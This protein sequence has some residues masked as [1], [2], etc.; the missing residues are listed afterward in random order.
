MYQVINYYQE[1]NQKITDF[2]LKSRY[3]WNDHISY[4]RNAIISIIANL[5]DI[6]AVSNRLLKNQEDIGTFMSPYYSTEQVNTLVNLLKQHINIATYVI[7]GTEGSEEQWRANGREIVNHMYQMNRMFWPTSVTEPIWTKH[8][9]M[10]I[11]QTDARKNIMW[12]D[13]IIAY[14]ENHTCMNELAD[15]ISNGIIYQ[16]IDMFCSYMTGE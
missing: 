1:N 12:N 3:L 8:L 11:A 9:D 14:D 4:T 5:P 2:K 7:K 16:N 6:E 13:D 10:T 15:L